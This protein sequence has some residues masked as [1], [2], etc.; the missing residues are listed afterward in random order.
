MPPDTRPINL[1]SKADTDYGDARSVHF[2]LQAEPQALK[3]LIELIEFV[4]SLKER[5]SEITS[6]NGAITGLGFFV[7]SPELIR[8]L[9]RVLKKRNLEKVLEDSWVRLP[10]AFEIKV[11]YDGLPLGALDVVV[12]NQITVSEDGVYISTA[13]KG[14][15]AKLDSNHL[16]YE[17][18][19]HLASSA[20]TDAASQK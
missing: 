7:E 9:K 16:D 17:F 5:Y 12:R 4:R 6:L 1:L 2:L 8:E 14:T 3:R 13:Q 19:K 15:L 18:V 11:D 10:D 20:H